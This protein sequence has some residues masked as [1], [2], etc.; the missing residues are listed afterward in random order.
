MSKSQMIREL[1]LPYK[2]LIGHRL[3]TAASGGL[4]LDQRVLFSA[5]LCKELLEVDVLGQIVFQEWVLAELG[6]SPRASVDEAA[7]FRCES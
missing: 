2:S 3:T 4:T 6:L 1:T 7:H 5:G